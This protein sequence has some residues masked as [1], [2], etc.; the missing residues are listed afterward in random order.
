LTK[1]YLLQ[2]ARSENQDN[3]I[4][5]DETP[6]KKLKSQH[7]DLLNTEAIQVDITSP[8][9]ELDADEGEVLDADEGEILLATQNEDDKVNTDSDSLSVDY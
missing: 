9:T 7:T 3:P 1:Q 2:R 6:P 8:A 4:T 5:V